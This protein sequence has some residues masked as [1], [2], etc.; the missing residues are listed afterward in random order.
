MAIKTGRRQFISALGGAVAAWPHIARAQQGQIRR[1]GLLMLSAENDVGQKQA[2]DR[3]VKQLAS[4]GWVDGLNVKVDL[5][6]S[7]GDSAKVKENAR[8]L[9]EAPCDVIIPEG[10]LPT[11]VLQ[12]ATG[13]I[14]VV[15]WL[16]PD[17]VGQGVVTNMARPGANITGFTNF[18]FTIAGKWLGLLKDIDPAIAS[19]AL[20]YNPSL[21]TYAE[22]FLGVLM[23]TAPSFGVSV[24]E[25]KAHNAAE[26]EAAMTAFAQ[27]GN[28]SG[29]VLA[30]PGALA[31][32][33]RDLIAQLGVRLRIPVI[34]AYRFFVDGGGLISYGVNFA[35]HAGQ[36]AAYADRILKGARPANLP[37]QAPTNYELIINLKAAKT[38]GLSI[39]QTLLAPR[40]R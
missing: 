12:R 21:E 26:I 11:S 36:T 29:G 20:L 6:W 15:F 24:S 5:R 33:N 19:V 23:E 22:R 2:V 16:V 7:D 10:I 3:I 35:Q 8:Q 9:V 37:V 13:T 32:A 30:S 31:T 25:M 17:P 38:L 40:T 39:P 1:I 4:L 27:G 18:E 14:P 28:L 34:Y